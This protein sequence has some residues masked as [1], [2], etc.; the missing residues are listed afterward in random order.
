MDSNFI[1]GVFSYPDMEQPVIQDTITTEQ[2]ST[3]VGR[4]E[5]SDSDSDAETRIDEEYINQE[6]YS[7]LDQEDTNEPLVSKI[8]HISVTIKDIRSFVIGPAQ[9]NMQP[10]DYLNEIP[11]MFDVECTLNGRDIFIV[12]V[13]VN[14]EEAYNVF[15]M[16]QRTVIGQSKTTLVPCIHYPRKS[17]EYG[18]YFCNVNDYKY[19]SMIHT[20]L[21]PGEAGNMH[22]IL[23]VFIDQETNEYAKPKDLMQTE[24]KTTVIEPKP[25][26]PIQQLEAVMERVAVK[27][28]KQEQYWGDD[29]EFTNLYNNG[30][31]DYL[32]KDMLER[33]FTPVRQPSTSDSSIY[34]GEFP[35]LPQPNHVIAP[36]KEIKKKETRRRVMRIIPQKTIPTP[37]ST[38]TALLER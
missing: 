17:E 8:F 14:V 4:A 16:I 15:S 10:I 20:K 11:R 34:S 22:V 18:L 6:D 25:M 7:E 9:K 32:P 24:K 38:G 26:E 1:E 28:E 19:K 31:L 35:S 13:E 36:R 12:G 33:A 5:S 27:N 37:V 21:E 29:R 2:P 3:V 23:P 30:T